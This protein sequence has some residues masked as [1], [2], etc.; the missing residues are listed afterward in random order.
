MP[1]I[2]R[3]ICLFY[4]LFLL[5]Q[6]GT[7]NISLPGIVEMICYAVKRDIKIIYRSFVLPQ[8]AI[9]KC[10]ENNKLKKPKQYYLT[11]TEL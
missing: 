4:S 6:P 10:K 1:K 2:Y 11:M 5:G 8:K 9:T 3:C 7:R